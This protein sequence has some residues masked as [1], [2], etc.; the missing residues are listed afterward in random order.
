MTRPPDMPRTSQTHPL[1]IA[2]IN[3]P[4]GGRIGLTFCPGKQD[5]QAMT[6]AWSRDLAADLAAIRDWGG[7]ILLTLME[8]HEL[9]AL[10]VPDLGCKAELLG[11]EWHHLP[12]RDACVPDARFE[13]LWPS[14]CPRLQ[15]ALGQGGSVV[16]HC[17][18][19]LGRTGLVAGLLLVE[20]GMSPTA[21]LNRVRSA[22]PGA[23]ETEA[24]AQY[25]LHAGL[26]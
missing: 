19:G 15:N 14:V 11:L 13:S 4:G 7:N 23:V 5:P 16:I 24:Q 12:I 22:R 17:K 1:Q 3:M 25:L 10:G 9:A 2:G 8:S 20:Q 18:G 26:A 21:A 6:G